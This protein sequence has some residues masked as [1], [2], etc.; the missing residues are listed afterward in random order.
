[1]VRDQNG[2]HCHDGNSRHHNSDRDC[3]D[4]PLRN[5][6]QRAIRE[7]GAHLRPGFVRETL[8][9]ECHAKNRN[10]RS[11]PDR[12]LGH[13]GPLSRNFHLGL[14]L[15]IP[16]AAPGRHRPAQPERHGLQSTVT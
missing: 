5:D 8:R 10:P 9:G 1:M 4:D 15:N 11:T 12:F 13:A 2:Y 7:I 6:V 3:D 16:S 14:N